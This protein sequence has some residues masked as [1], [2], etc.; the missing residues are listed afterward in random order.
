MMQKRWYKL[1]NGR[2]VYRFPPKPIETRSDLAFPMLRLDT[3]EPIQSQADGKMYDS[4]SALRKTYRADGNP[5]GINYLEVG[6]E[7]TTTYSPPKRDDAKAIE[8]IERAEAD[9]AAGRA[10]D[11]GT[12]DQA[13]LTVKAVV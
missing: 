1:E 11:I 10:P 2:E 8:A 9:I 4:L 3:I 7:N 12:V 13:E 6:N 5:Q